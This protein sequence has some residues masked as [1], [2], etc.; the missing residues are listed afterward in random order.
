MPTRAILYAGHDLKFTTHN[1]VSQP[2]GV[3]RQADGRQSL[4]PILLRQTG[5]PLFLSPLMSEHRMEQPIL[6]Q[7]G[8][9]SVWIVPNKYSQGLL[10]RLFR[11]EREILYYK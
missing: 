10:L 4:Q 2:V 1:Q 9:H 7:R 11:M 5:I 3:L 8:Q 6:A